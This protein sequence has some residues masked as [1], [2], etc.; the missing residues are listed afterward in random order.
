M[1]KI[2]ID[3]EGVED[4]G[5]NIFSKTYLMKLRNTPV[6]SDP[7]EDVGEELNVMIA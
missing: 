4:D 3:V 7:Y 2:N 6:S 5:K 1:Y